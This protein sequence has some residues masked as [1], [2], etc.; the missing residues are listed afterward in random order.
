MRHNER[1]MLVEDLKSIK[2]EEL[3]KLNSCED[4]FCLFHERMTDLIN[5]HLPLKTLRRYCGDKPWV[6]Q[7][8]KDKVRAR[9]R[10]YKQG[11]SVLYKKLRNDANRMAR[12]LRPNFYKKKIEKLKDLDPSK[13]W[14]QVKTLSGQ[15]SQ[16]HS[17]LQTLA[18]K[19]T[20][21][22]TLELANKLNQMFC[23]VSCSLPKLNYIPLPVI[24]PDSFIITPY[25]V[26]KKLMKT[27]VRKATRADIYQTGYYMTVQV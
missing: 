2:W 3:Y 16:K 10:A 23:K 12:R 24:I 25:D 27:N 20:D 26:E 18:L 9:Q 7:A 6:T 8:F 15:K 14:N 11:N 13:W 21:G 4:Q 22:D 1:V 19:E 5:T 17:N